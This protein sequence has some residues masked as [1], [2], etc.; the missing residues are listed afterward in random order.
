[1]EIDL[2]DG[3][4]LKRVEIERQITGWIPI[5]GSRNFVLFLPYQEKSKKLPAREAELR[6]V[7]GRTLDVVASVELP[8]QPTNPQI[9]FNKKFLYL[10]NPGVT[11]RKAERN[12]REI[13]Y[14]VSLTSAKLVKTID[15]GFNATQIVDFQGKQLIVAGFTRGIRIRG[16][17]DGG[18]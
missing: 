14:V 11:H 16:L 18:R 4:V 10:T 12:R 9:S 17:R 13:L 1:M 2:D 6:F 7:R 8:G 15:I 3:S 5:P